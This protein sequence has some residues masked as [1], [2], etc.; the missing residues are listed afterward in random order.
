MTD[1]QQRFPTPP[2]QALAEG[3][4]V[5]MGALL[6]IVER[7]TA[8]VRAGKIVEAMALQDDKAALSQRYMQAVERLKGAEAA[9]AATAPDLLTALRR[10]HEAFRAMLQANLTVL[11]TAHAVSE[12]IVR[13]VNGEMQRKHVPQTYTASGQHAGASTRQLS[14]LAVSRTL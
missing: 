2:A 8:L 1:A 12:G 9:L 10:H 3:L 11:A 6:D 7:E 14:P 13:G 5:T 4:I